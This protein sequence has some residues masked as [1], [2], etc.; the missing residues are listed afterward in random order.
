MKTNPAIALVIFLLAGCANP[1]TKTMTP[2]QQDTAKSEIGKAVEGIF[3]SLE[4]KDVEALFQYYSDSPDF[5]FFTTD[6]S[7]ADFREAKNHNAAWLKS[8]STLIIKTTDEKFTFLPGNDVV[9]SWTGIFTMTLVSG[10]KFKIDRFGITFIFRKTD[11]R[12]K[13]IYQHSSSL[14]PVQDLPV[15]QN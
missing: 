11:D 1:G 12:W 3:H 7:M 5:V 15:N 14:P 9:C 8:L 2:R 10:E 4:N 6:G 13:V